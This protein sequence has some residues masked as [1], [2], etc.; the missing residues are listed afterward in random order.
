MALSNVTKKTV[1]A[2]HYVLCKTLLSQ[3]KGLMFSRPKALV[4][5]FP[6]ERIVSLHMFFVFYPI[7][8]LFLNS[9]QCVVEIKKNFRPFTWHTSRH[10]AMYVVELPV[11]T[12]EKTRTQLGDRLRL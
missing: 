9:A 7:D 1:I 12:I 11:G 2:L 10:K 3:A 8:V 5:F 4:M 6:S